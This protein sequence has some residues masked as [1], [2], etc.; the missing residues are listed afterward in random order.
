MTAMTG[1]AA[2]SP[3]PGAPLF[4]NR[5]AR[6]SSRSS[7]ARPRQRRPD[8][9]TARWQSIEVR[10]LAALAA[11][12]RERSF[13]RAADELGYVQSAISGQIAHLERAAG[14]RLV[15]RASGTAAVELT[16]AGHVL[17]RHTE[18]ILSRFDSAQADIGSMSARAAAVVRVAGLEHLAPRQAARAVSSFRAR[19]PFSRIHLETSVGGDDGMKLLASGALDVLVGVQPR[20]ATTHRTAVTLFEDPYLLI[21]RAA[22]NP[23]K[24]VTVCELKSLR[25]LLPGTGAD[26]DRLEAVLRSIGI[27]P[28][29]SIQAGDFAT[30]EALVASGFGAA[31]MPGRGARD[32]GLAARDLSH[33]IA[34]AEVTVTV[35]SATEPPPAVL[36]FTAALHDAVRDDD[37]LSVAAG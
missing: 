2:Q 17:L 7:D 25:L 21:E 8:S 14:T 1:T 32:S 13:R 18:E 35:T 19:Y 31:V 3:S 9:S 36:A 28:D 23:M 29:L 4:G 30:V 33:L 37:L 5:R 10:H 6:A 20:A 34:P 15:E 11:V 24:P 26:R 12:A 27:E 16:E 22:R